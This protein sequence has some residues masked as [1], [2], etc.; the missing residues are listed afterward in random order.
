VQAGS[1]CCC[2]TAPTSLFPAAGWEEVDPLEYLTP[3]LETIKSP[4]TSG[5]ITLVALASLNKIISRGILGEPLCACVHAFAMLNSCMPACVPAPSS[6]RRPG[7]NTAPQ[8]QRLPAW[9][10]AAPHSSPHP[11]APSHLPARRHRSGR[12]RSRGH[13]GSGRWGH[14]VQV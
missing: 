10:P 1:N 6:S 2:G 9:P 4:E 11:A 13:P 7:G 3:F 5:P 14:P 8:R 12:L